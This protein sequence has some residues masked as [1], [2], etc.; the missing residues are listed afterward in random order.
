M[1]KSTKSPRVEFNRDIKATIQTINRVDKIPIDI[2]KLHNLLT[3][4][5]RDSIELALGLLLEESGLLAGSEDKRFEQVTILAGLLEAL[6]LD[7]SD[8]ERQHV[9]R[10]FA[11]KFDREFFDYLVNKSEGKEDPM[12]R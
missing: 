2:K 9:V 10:I 7:L 8:K 1:I 6:F 4:L 11:C 3:E 5:D 12:F